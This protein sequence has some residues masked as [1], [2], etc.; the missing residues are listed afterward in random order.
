[1]LELLWV[2]FV[3]VATM[4]EVKVRR[5]QVVGLYISSIVPPGAGEDIRWH[6]MDISLLLHNTVGASLVKELEREL[7]LAP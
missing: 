6:M 5:S 4:N 2:I 1:M 7:M 3:L